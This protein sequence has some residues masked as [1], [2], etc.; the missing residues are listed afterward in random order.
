[1][2]ISNPFRIPQEMSGYTNIAAFSIVAVIALAIASDVKPELQ[3]VLKV[4]WV[5]MVLSVIAAVALDGTQGSENSVI[6]MAPEYHLQPQNPAAQTARE[7][8][9]DKQTKRLQLDLTTFLANERVRIEG[10]VRTLSPATQDAYTLF[11]DRFDREY[12]ALTKVEQTIQKHWFALFDGNQPILHEK[13][14]PEIW[15]AIMQTIM[16]AVF[17]TATEK[18]QWETFLQLHGAN[19]DV[20]QLIVNAAFRNVAVPQ[21]PASPLPASPLSASPLSASPR[22]ASS[23]SPEV[24]VSPNVKR[25]PQYDNNSCW[26]DS[27]LMAILGCDT[28]MRAVLVDPKYNYGVTIDTRSQENLR[29]ELH[30]FYQYMLTDATSN[31][32][33]FTN[34][35][36]DA[37]SNSSLRQLLNKI[38][39][40]EFPLHDP[41]DARTAFETGICPLCPTGLQGFLVND[42]FFREPA[43][44]L[45]QTFNQ[46]PCPAEVHDKRLL[47]FTPSMVQGN[48]P[49]ELQYTEETEGDRFERK[50]CKYK[51]MDKEQRT[52]VPHGFIAFLERV[53]FGDYDGYSK[54]DYP[55][56]S[57]VHDNER[58]YK[59]TAMVIY[60]HRRIIPSHYITVFLNNGHWYKYD[61]TVDRGAVNLV[62]SDAEMD[63][64]PYHKTVAQ[65]HYHPTDTFPLSRHSAV[66][67]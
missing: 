62:A 13:D 2:S 55:I 35:R 59:L 21:Y 50:S 19:D 4:M 58:T 28:V 18:E 1:M 63:F 52:H 24:S 38:N 49:V 47:T 43:D 40:T 17:E 23:L 34:K 10:I 48:K 12:T 6:Q 15:Q 65:L 20:L 22:S 7:L 5:P 29:L 61:N 14:I 36:L 41:S 39:S 56:R 16:L 53:P 44:Q 42:K 67:Q 32:T 31:N 27:M 30:S 3:P 64:E 46:Q 11:K 57:L 25:G 26:L 60:K 8:V 37:T 54:F 45:A 66:M 9:G 33:F 51:R